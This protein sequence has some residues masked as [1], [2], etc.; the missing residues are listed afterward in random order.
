MVSKDTT[1]P[2]ELKEEVVKAREEEG[3]DYFDDY[4]REKKVFE[5]DSKEFGLDKFDVKVHDSKSELNEHDEHE[6]GSNEF[7]SD[8]NDSEIFTMN[9]FNTL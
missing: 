8:S 5:E 1:T 6:E 9:D 2:G 4:E 3:Q 7:D